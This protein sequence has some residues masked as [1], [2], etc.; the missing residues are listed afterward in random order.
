LT[1][2]TA[3]RLR[4]SRGASR[5]W[6]ASARQRTRSSARRRCRANNYLRSTGETMGRPRASKYRDPGEHRGYIFRPTALKCP[7]CGGPCKSLVTKK[8][9][10][11]RGVECTECDWSQYPGNAPPLGSTDASRAAAEE[12]RAR[13][14][15][16][17]QPV[18][19]RNRQKVPKSAKPSPPAEND[20]VECPRTGELDEGRAT[21]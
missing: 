17:H 12:Q 13:E 6:P 16:S 15:K 19:A 2:G 21:P 1:T 9:G 8:L 3:C 4:A 5:A 20:A 18:Y 7:R 11:A 10:T 14:A